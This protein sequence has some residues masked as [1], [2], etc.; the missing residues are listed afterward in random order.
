[1]GNTQGNVSTS[2]RHA[3]TTKGK[4]GDELAEV[5]KTEQREKTSLEEGGSLKNGGFPL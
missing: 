3:R 1:M 2:T 4:D 5:Q